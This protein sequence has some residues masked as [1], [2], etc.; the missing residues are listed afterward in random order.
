MEGCVTVQIS[1]VV[2]IFW[3]REVVEDG[4][5]RF[6]SNGSTKE[7]VAQCTQGGKVCI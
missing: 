6:I 5:F 1:S 7:S 2:L 4:F 3:N